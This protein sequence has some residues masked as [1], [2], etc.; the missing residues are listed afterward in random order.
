VQTSEIK[1]TRKSSSSTASTRSSVV[2][3][4][5]HRPDRAA[6]RRNVSTSRSKAPPRRSGVCELW[7]DNWVLQEWCAQ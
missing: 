1:L 4:D 7:D 6:R 3:A 2:I 5:S